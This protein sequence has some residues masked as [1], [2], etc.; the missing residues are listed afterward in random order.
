MKMFGIGGDS[1]IYRQ[2][3]VLLV[4][5]VSLPKN[6]TEITPD[7]DIILAHGEVTGHAHRLALPP[8]IYGVDNG[9][10]VAMLERKVKLWDAGAERFIQVL[11]KTVLT[12]EEHSAV[13]IE[14]GVYK[15]IRQKEYDPAEAAR[16]RRVAD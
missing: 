10:Q 9:K 11:E 12:H 15:V 6:V 3:D 1:G 8:M 7:G 14:P 2:G 13:P 5:V 4:R 16:Q